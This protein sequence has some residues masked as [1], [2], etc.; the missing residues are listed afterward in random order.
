MNFTATMYV[1]TTGKAQPCL[2][3]VSHALLACDLVVRCN[4]VDLLLADAR[5]A[6][7]RRA[8][9]VCRHWCSCA[10]PLLKHRA[11]HQ[12]VSIRAKSGSP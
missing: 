8:K 2:L 3:L 6:L 1:C 4:E 11:G 5:V 9:D 7:Q 12:I 10:P